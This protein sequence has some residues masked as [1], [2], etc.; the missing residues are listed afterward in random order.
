MGG[1]GASPRPRDGRAGLAGGLLFFRNAL[2]RTPFGCIVYVHSTERM[3]GNHCVVAF[4]AHCRR[5][6]VATLIESQCGQ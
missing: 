4:R 3:Q 5:R 1:A 2:D 6:G